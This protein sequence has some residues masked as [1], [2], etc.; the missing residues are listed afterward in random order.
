MLLAIDTQS[1]LYLFDSE[2]EVVKAF[3][4][5]D[6]E[7]NEYEFCDSAGSKLVPEITKP[8]TRFRAGAFRLVPAGEPDINTPTMFVNRARELGRKCS[9]ISTLNDARAFF[10]TRV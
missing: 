10:Q 8:V 6:V 7:N 2:D 5:I 4:A 9:G 3:E 1:V